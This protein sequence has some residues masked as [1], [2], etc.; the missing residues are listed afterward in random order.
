MAPLLMHGFNQLLEECNDQHIMWVSF[1][2]CLSNILDAVEG[3][4]QSWPLLCA[5][6]MYI[7]IHII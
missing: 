7:V 1:A 2:D 3:E 5:V 6:A 4:L